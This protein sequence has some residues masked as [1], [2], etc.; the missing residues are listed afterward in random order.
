[1]HALTNRI[2]TMPNEALESKPYS[3]FTMELGPMAN[4]IYLI[5]DKKSKKAAVVDPAWDVAAIEKCARDQ[6]VEITDI[7]LTHSHHDHI[8][9]INELLSHYDA[10]LHLT[11]AEAKFWHTD[12]HLPSLH[13]GGDIIQLGETEVKILHTP[14]HTPGSACYSIDD[15]LITGDTLFVYG[16]GRCDMQG[17]DA[18]QMYDTLRKIQTELPAS[19]NTLPGHNYSTKSCCTLKEQAE[20]NPFMHYLDET[21]KSK[22]IQLRMHQ[23]DQRRKEPLAPILESEM[24]QFEN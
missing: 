23:H 9:G 12:I 7:L 15:Q 17:G 8:N 24:S 6:Q 2:I 10:Q 19:T 14:G 1:L 11:H 16:C 5:V 4:F 3:I 22:F 18:N 20:A 13:H 21:N